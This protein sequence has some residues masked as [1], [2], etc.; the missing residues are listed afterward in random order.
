[1][2]VPRLALVVTAFVVAVAGAAL[3]AVISPR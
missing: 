3:V 2:A 1:V